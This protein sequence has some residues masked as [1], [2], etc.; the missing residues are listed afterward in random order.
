MN[1][2]LIGGTSEIGLAIVRRLGAE[3]PPSGAAD[4]CPASLPARA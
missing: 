1:V 4:N 2:L 3:A